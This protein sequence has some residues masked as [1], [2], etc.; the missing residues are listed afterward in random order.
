M[1]NSIKERDDQDTKYNPAE[2]LS[3]G[4]QAALDQIEAGL[5]DDNLSDYSQDARSIVE[6]KES[7][8]SSSIISEVTG[9]KTP[10]KIKFN[11]KKASPVAGIGIIAIIFGTALAGSLGPASLLIN[12]K[13]NMMNRWDT[14]NIT[15]EVRSNMLLSK[16]LGEANTSG[17]NSNILSCKYSKPSSKFLKKLDVAGIKALDS[18]GNTIDK[19]SWISGKS[20]PAKYLLPDGKEITAA[21]FA[22]E[23][24]NN[25]TARSAF[26]KAHNPKW[27]TWSDSVANGIFQKF[28]ISKI[29]PPELEKVTDSKS[30]TSAAGDISK[31]EGLDG[32]KVKANLSSEINDFTE[33][34]AKKISKSLGNG[35][36]FTDVATMVCV[37]T[38]IPGVAVKVVQAAQ[39]IQLTRYAMMFL[40]VADA[41]KSG[42][43]TPA[44]VSALG[45]IL[46]N[47]VNGKS[48]VDS[49]GIKNALFGDT[50]NNGSG[51]KK[52]V[53]GGNMGF[54]AKLSNARDDP[55][56]RDVCNAS[57]SASADLAESAIRAA[58]AAAA[59]TPVGWGML[60]VDAGFWTA[61]ET[62][63]LDDLV[64]WILGNAADALMAILP[65]E[66]ITKMVAGDLTSNLTEDEP[67][68][69]MASGVNHILASVSNSGGNSP[70]NKTDAIAFLR[71][72]KQPILAAR[73]EEDRATMSPL[74]SSSPYTF[75]GTIATQLIPHMSKMSTLSG[76]I[77]T[78]GSL[79]SNKVFSMINPNISA[80]SS[81][82]SIDPSEFELCSDPLIQNANV[83][84]SPWCAPY[85]GVPSQYIN[86]DPDDV[87]LSLSSQLD[88]E[89]KPKEDSDLSEWI[90]DCFS[91]DTTTLS[92]C[93]INS[94]EKADYSLYYIDSRIV[95]AMDEEPIST[96][97]V[98]DGSSPEAILPTEGGD[99]AWPLNK[100]LYSKK[101]SVFLKGHGTSSGTFVKPGGR[102]GKAAD[103]GANSLGVSV[104]EPIY[105]V[106]SGTVTRIGGGHA[107]IIRSSVPGGTVDIA[108]AHGYVNVKVGDTVTAG[109]QISAIGNLGNSRGAHLHIDMNYN[110]QQFCPQ[111]LFIFMNDNP[112]KLPDFPSLVSKAKGGSCSRL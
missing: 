20:R 74:D 59:T 28:G 9:K 95:T 13:E 60:A 17:C 33:K 63:V 6:S 24:R 99:I 4:E 109:Q 108:Y 106:L 8:S 87:L 92:S 66:D 82:D 57:T 27:V 37:G 94:Q 30:A 102:T 67:G 62:G 72:V 98:E 68:D 56:V 21:N 96:G 101:K 47:T 90:A 2:A 11:F 22:E 100:E 107:V 14:Q 111:D 34:N 16:R 29:P 54:L 19:Q 7:D 83:A 38:A 39:I 42:E 58:K 75:M 40:T 5:N 12:L 65:M 88:D 81:S 73:A 50:K 79:F 51:Y 61:A 53:P 91:N 26:R 44:Q 48:G 112:G 18:K 89:G 86:K 36:G 103:L 45:M 43:A 1:A 71:D 104:R 84:S 52:F 25:P 97:T 70:M 76:S 23:M 55:I 31:S 41:I 32:D 69:A 80:S 110:Q 93:I 35:V 15:A 77:S 64:G 46:T 78:L 49:F 3:A 105:S 85:Y 10:K